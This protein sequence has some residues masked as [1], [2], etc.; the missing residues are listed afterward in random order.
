[1][2][3]TQVADGERR[4]RD[5]RRPPRRCARLPRAGTRVLER[6]TGRVAARTDDG[7]GPAERVEA[8]LQR[9]DDARALRPARGRAARAADEVAVSDRVAGRGFPVG[10]HR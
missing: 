6:V 9:P 1:M 2:S 3:S 7:A 8:D 4:R 10:S 5:P